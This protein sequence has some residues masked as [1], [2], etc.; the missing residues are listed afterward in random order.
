L[1]SNITFSAAHCSFAKQRILT[2]GCFNVKEIFRFAYMRE[3]IK[4]L[5]LYTTIYPGVEDYLKDWFRSVREQ[6]D[7]KFKTWI[8]VDSLTVDA[9]MDAMGGDP[10]ATWV[11]AAP[12]DTP[13]QV[14]Q[15]ALEQLVETC[16]GVVLVDSDDILHPSRVA[17][18]RES[19]KKNDLVGCALRLVDQSGGDV[20]MAFR[21]PPHAAPADVLPRN[22][23][24]GLSNSAYRSDLL[25]RCLPIP[26]D[27]ALVDWYLAT[28]A[29]L[30]GAK[31]D[32]DDVIRMDYRQHGMNMARV[33]P[34]FNPIQVISDCN[35]VRHHFQVMLATP[36]AG[37][38]ADRLASLEVVASDIESFHLH[39]VLNPKRL[40]RYVEA[41]NDLDLAPLWWSSV[42]NPVLKDMW[43]P[44]K[45]KE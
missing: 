38:M 29:W 11:P 44:I 39:V 31:L 27:V 14:R 4:S 22:N 6:T 3:P 24:F 36:L 40:E 34:P 7:Q 17:S 5:A 45:E 9:I 12:G 28:R 1:H 37:A 42:A 19:L 21:M 16:D 15:R 18:A 10:N 2:I 30:L 33:R 23:V 8:G 35:R 26:D 25:R 13:A 41:L 20:G 43:S 32:F